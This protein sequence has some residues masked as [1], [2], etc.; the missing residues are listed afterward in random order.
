MT[1]PFAD[2]L[3]DA[4]DRAG[5]PCVVGL[6]PHLAHL[7]E[8]F[9]AAR[10]AA[11]PRAERARAIGDFLVEIVDA[12]AG[13][14]PAVKPQSAFFEAFGADG[15]HEFERVVA[16]SKDAGLLVVGDVKRGDI[17]STAAAYAQAF[18]TGL[19]GQDPRTLCDAITVN[20]Y[21]GTD[22]I[23]PFVDACRAADAGL[24]VLVRTSNPSSAEL[25]AVEAGAD[26]E[27]VSDL[28]ADAVVG[29]GSELVGERGWSSIGAVVG[30]T[31]PDELA[32][33]RERMPRTPLLLPGYGAQGAGAADVAGGFRDGLHGALVNSSRGILF[34]GSKRPEMHWKDAAVE[35]MESMASE[36]RAVLLER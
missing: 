28:V 6:D 13:R 10:D 31:H 23:A 29:W 9:S 4:V 1:A 7:P 36:L 18:L 17:G 35:A 2:R 11:A 30:A 33:L 20:P 34:A 21:L 14:V 24:Y 32:R 27:T 3:A 16:A 26:G 15:V 19:E 25:Q 12:C 22:S 5:N 8:E